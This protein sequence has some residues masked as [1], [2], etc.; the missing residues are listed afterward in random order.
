MKEAPHWYSGHPFL[1]LAVADP[2]DG[3]QTRRIGRAWRALPGL[4][5]RPSRLCAREGISE[6]EEAASWLAGIPLWRAGLFPIL[7][8][9]QRNRTEGER[10]ALFCPTST[11]SRPFPRC[12]HALHQGCPAGPPMQPSHVK[13]PCTPTSLLCRVCT[14]FVY[15]RRACRVSP[16][17]IPLSSKAPPILNAG[18]PGRGHSKQQQT[19]SVDPRSVLVHMAE[20]RT[21]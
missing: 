7:F 17:A 5:A 4:F 19:E 1:S 6:S 3:Q 2:F 10:T 11:L 8:L 13:R 15:E 12:L 20:R 18:L 9:S 21:G 16:A 14:H